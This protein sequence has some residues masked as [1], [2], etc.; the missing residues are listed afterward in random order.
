MCEWWV[1]V[2]GGCVSGGCGVVDV[3]EWWMCVSGECV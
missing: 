1:S 2:S 3:C